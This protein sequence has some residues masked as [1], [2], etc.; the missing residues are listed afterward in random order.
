MIYKRGLVVN[1]DGYLRITSKRMG[2]RHQYAHRAY[3]NRQ[4]Q[5]SLGRG[6]LPTEE[7]H[8]LCRNRRCWPPTDFH[9]LILDAVIHHAIDGGNHANRH[10]R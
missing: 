6:L 4:M 7:V 5:Y 9:L 1:E 10:R 3:A 8:H 2:L